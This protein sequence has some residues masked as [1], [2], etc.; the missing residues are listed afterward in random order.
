MR[1][2]LAAAL[3]ALTVACSGADDGPEQADL[4]GDPDVEQQYEETDAEAEGGDANAEADAKGQKVTTSGNMEAEWWE[5][6]LPR[7]GWTLHCQLDARTVAK[8][9]PTCSTSGAGKLYGRA[10]SKDRAECGVAD[11]QLQRQQ[12]RT[13]RADG[14]EAKRFAVALWGIDGHVAFTADSVRVNVYAALARRGIPFSVFVHVVGEHPSDWRKPHSTLA[15]FRDLQGVYKEG[16]KPSI[17]FQRDPPRRLDKALLGLLRED[18]WDH[19]KADTWRQAM[20]DL[21]SL[22]RVTALWHHF[23]ERRARPFRAVLYVSLDSLWLTPLPPAVL[24]W[25]NTCSSSDAD[26]IYLP[27]A[28]SGLSVAGDE[29]RVKSVTDGI[30]IG[31]PSAMIRW[32]NR[33]DGVRRFEEALGGSTLRGGQL[34]AWALQQWSHPDGDG[35]K[36]PADGSFR[37]HAVN[38][39]QHDGCMAVGIGREGLPHKNPTL[40]GGYGVWASVVRGGGVLLDRLVRGS[41]A[42]VTAECGSDLELSLRS[43]PQ[44][45]DY[46]CNKQ[47]LK[48]WCACPTELASRVVSLRPRDREATTCP[49]LPEKPDPPMPPWQAPVEG[50]DRGAARLWSQLVMGGIDDG[51]RW[52]GSLHSDGSL[53]KCPSGGPMCRP[54]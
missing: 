8:N 50:D 5:Q 51:K 6:L 35:S 23:Q 12:W 10:Q 38:S 21:V 29:V 36:P 28:M 15:D 53:V 32:G 34:A 18:G 41:Y 3:A 16:D 45:R 2:A 4:A 13:E 7:T 46:V 37:L 27:R 25:F 14:R 33:V 54:S 24:D 9:L 48:D 11:A 19:R 44:L 1:P 49:P 39:T 22:K 52:A 40:S 42:Q 43:S 20:Y 47:G 17:F 30:A 26:R 31:T